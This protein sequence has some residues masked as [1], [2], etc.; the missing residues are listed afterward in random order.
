MD[1]SVYAGHGVRIGA[2]TIAVAR[3]LEDFLIQTLGRWKIL[4]YLD[5][6]L[7]TLPSYASIYACINGIIHEV[8]FHSI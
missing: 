2:A 1:A 3:G 6:R 7:G 5:Y 8:C 4:A